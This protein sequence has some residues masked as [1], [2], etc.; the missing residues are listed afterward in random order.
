M[1]KKFYSQLRGK[2]FQQSISFYPYPSLSI[3]IFIS[4]NLYLT[5]KFLKFDKQRWPGLYQ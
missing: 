4:T 3:S 1:G 2:Q 5:P